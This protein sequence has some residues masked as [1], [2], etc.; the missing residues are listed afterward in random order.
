[1]ASQHEHSKISIKQKQNTSVPEVAGAS[2]ASQTCYVNGLVVDDTNFPP[3]SWHIEGKTL[4]K[5]ALRRRPSA[6]NS[7]TPEPQPDPHRFSHE[8]LGTA[9]R[10]FLSMFRNML[11]LINLSFVKAII[12]LL[13]AVLPLTGFLASY[14]MARWNTLRMRRPGADLPL[15]LQWNVNGV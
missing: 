9:L 14:V 10:T 7:R 13:D 6:K 2:Q 5:S 12:T 15:V 3:M 8:S 1:M 4:G 11:H